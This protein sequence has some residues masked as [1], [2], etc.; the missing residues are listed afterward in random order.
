MNTLTMNQFVLEVLRAKRLELQDVLNM[1]SDQLDDLKLP[2]RVLQLISKIKESGMTDLEE[3]KEAISDE[4]ILGSDDNDIVK[5]VID[6]YKGDEDATEESSVDVPASEAEEKNVETPEVKT[7]PTITPE[8]Q[9]IIDDVVEN[10][11]VSKEELI[12]IAS[13]CTEKSVPAMS[14][15]IKTIIGDKEVDLEV[16]RDV[17]KEQVKLNKSK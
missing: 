1:S 5:E 10:A 12:A 11:T 7:E 14:K 3:I 17:I 2:N 4:R 9:D 16:L 8:V 15:K 6:E 13:K